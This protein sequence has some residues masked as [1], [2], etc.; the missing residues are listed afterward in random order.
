M[1]AQI[2]KIDTGSKEAPDTGSKAVHDAV[3]P[4]A[5]DKLIEKFHNTVSLMRG[6][7]L[8]YK[9]VKN[10]KLYKD[11]VN[12]NNTLY[13][14]N[15]H[16]KTVISGH[17]LTQ[18][19]ANIIDIIMTKLNP[20]VSKEGYV[21]VQPSFYE[22]QKYLGWKYKNDTKTIKELLSQLIETK[23]SIFSKT[24]KIFH[25]FHILKKVWTDNTINTIVFSPEFIDL[26]F[27]DYLINYRPS[28]DVILSFKYSTNQAIARFLIS[29]KDINIGIEKLLSAI[30]I[31]RS[32]SRKEKVRIKKHII[33]E[34]DKFEELGMTINENLTFIYQKNK[35]NK[36]KVYFSG[37]FAV[38]K[39]GSH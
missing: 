26:Y 28:V 6:V 13:F 34:K 3:D 1:D 4:D 37:K 39:G 5:I 24:R 20:Q 10:T 27:K 15:S 35:K 30:G 12:N 31:D 32:V 9:K 18:L 19:H 2:I 21:F 17:I 7:F 33:Q 16:I 38:A 29:Q 11:F 8:P 14:E 22:L 25:E 23:I 36:E